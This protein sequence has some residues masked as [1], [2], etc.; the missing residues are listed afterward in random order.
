MAADAMMSSAAGLG[1]GRLGSSLTLVLPPCRAYNTPWRD[2]RLRYVGDGR[3]FWRYIVEQS[4]GCDNE[5]MF[6]EVGTKGRQQ[7][8]TCLCSCIIVCV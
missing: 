3:P 6:E 1:C 4:T 2:S 8:D 5:A 7:Q